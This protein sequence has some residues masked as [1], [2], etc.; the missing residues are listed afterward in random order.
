MLHPS[1]L[2]IESVKPSNRVLK[3][4]MMFHPTTTLFSSE[5]FST[6]SIWHELTQSD[7]S[8]PARRQPVGRRSTAFHNKSYNQW[9]ACNE[10]KIPLV[11]WK[12]QQ[13]WQEP[14][15]SRNRILGWFW[16]TCRDTRCL[17]GGKESWW[18]GWERINTNLFHDFPTS[19]YKGFL[20]L[21]TGL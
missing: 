3:W 12:V 17:P 13:S 6:C 11:R 5:L 7:S 20:P 9:R 1:H 18:W 15:Q 19:R 4:S 16:T 14:Y 21:I 2:W 8:Q 10:D